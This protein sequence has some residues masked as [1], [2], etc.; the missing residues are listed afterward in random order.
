[1]I[2]NKTTFWVQAAGWSGLIAG[3]GMLEMYKMTGNSSFLISLAIIVI[4]SAYLLATAHTSR[5]QKTSFIGR[6]SIFC[7]I[8]VSLIQTFFL[9]LA[10]RSVRN[11]SKSS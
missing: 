10:Y 5:W 2:K 6:V 1:M 11:G 7:L 9:W 4:F 3:T 8:F